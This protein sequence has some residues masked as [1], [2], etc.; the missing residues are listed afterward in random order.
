MKGSEGL[1]F[2]WKVVRGF[3]WK[4]VRVGVCVE[5]SEGFCVKGSEGLGFVWKV[6][7]GLCGRQ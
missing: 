4:A 3:V 1:G 2:V 7:R 5:G 6:V